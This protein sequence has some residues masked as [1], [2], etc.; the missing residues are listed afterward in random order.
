VACIALLWSRFG[1]YHWARLGAAARAGQA[2]GLDVVGIEVAGEDGEY[3]WDHIEQGWGARR[4]TLFPNDNYHDLGRSRIAQAVCSALD[5][6]DPAAVATNGWAMP[7]ARASLRWCSHRGRRC[8][9]MSETKSDDRPRTRWKEWGKRLMLRRF[10]AALVGGRAHAA[11]LCELGFSAGRIH[12]GYDAVD[13]EH[14]HSGAATARDHAETLREKLRLPKRYFLAST[15]FLRRK[16]VD[17]LLR[18]YSVY[19]HRSAGPPWG[20]VVLGRG[21]EEARLQSIEQALRVEGVIWPGFVQYPQ[22]PIYYG[23]AGAFVHA[24]KREAWGLVVN[25]AAASGLPL[26]VSKTVGAAAEL[27]WE[28]RNGLLFDPEDDEELA[29]ALLRISSATPYRRTAMARVSQETVR[30]WGPERFAGGL[31]AAAIP[32]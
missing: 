25:E 28:G 15:R 23:L 4:V 16:N 19:R 18:A 12:F 10:D 1:P 8:I 29:D 24:A 7:E 3:G 20:L 22:L 9:V 30:D 27:V 31:L 21:E 2:Q 5:E 32:D 26:I 14:F 6:L 17:G 11:Y 13:N